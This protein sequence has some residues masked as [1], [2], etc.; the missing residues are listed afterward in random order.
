MAPV[1][2]VPDNRTPVTA[3]IANCLDKEVFLDI[4]VL[5][6]FVR[7]VELRRQA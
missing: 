7:K 2:T 5:L 1:T 4:V 3:A 6:V